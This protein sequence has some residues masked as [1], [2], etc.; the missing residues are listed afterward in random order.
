MILGEPQV[1]VVAACRIDLELYTIWEVFTVEQMMLLRP[2][3]VGHDG[4]PRLGN[5]RR[6]MG[7]EAC[8]K[9]K[10]SCRTKSAI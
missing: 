8:R 9:S 3:G 10:R 1:N 7:E 4:W 2:L 6:A 5:S